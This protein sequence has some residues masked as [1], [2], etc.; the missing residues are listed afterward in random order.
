[1]FSKRRIPVIVVLIV[2]AL[3]P[4]FEPRSAPA[5]STRRNRG[6]SA[7]QQQN[8]LLQQQNAVLTAA[9]QTTALVQSAAQQN[10]VSPQG[11]VPSLI[12]F[13]QQQS[14]LQVA[15]QQTNA[16]LQVSY[17]QNNALAQTAL[18]QLNILQTA[19]QQSITL[20]GSLISQNGQLTPLQL[21]T[22]LQEQSL[23]TQLLTSQPPGLS[24]SGT[25]R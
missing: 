25:S 9:Q 17:R 6:L 21:Q 2:T 3:L 5:K 13:Q 4:A 22:L 15:L 11:P 8:A 1:V 24:R 10:N 16:L 12:G 18:R 19:Q 7:L 14:A 23:L 20:Q